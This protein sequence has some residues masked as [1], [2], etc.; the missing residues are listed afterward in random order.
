MSKLATKG[1]RRAALL[2]AL[3]KLQLEQRKISI[4]AVAREAGVTPALIHNTYPDVADRI[5]AL[6]GQQPEAK[7][8]R[9][10]QML[11]ALRAANKRLEEENAKVTADL[12]RLASIVQTLTDEV[13]RLQAADAGK[14]IE[15]VKRLKPQK[16]P[17]S[18]SG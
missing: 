7:A 2:G 18:S 15:L 16:S 17:E 14:A 11:Q 4:S 5:R 10:R 9:D 8:G 12:A 1:D 3:Q 6:T 13:T